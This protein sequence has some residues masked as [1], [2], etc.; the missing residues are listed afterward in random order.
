MRHWSFDKMTRSQYTLARSLKM[1]NRRKLSP[2]HPILVKPAKKCQ[3]L[4]SSSSLSLYTIM[5][6]TIPSSTLR[7]CPLSKWPPTDVVDSHFEATPSNLWL[8]IRKIRCKTIWI[9]KNLAP[10]IS[11]HHSC[12]F[13]I[14]MLPITCPGRANLFLVEFVK[15]A[16]VTSVNKWRI[17]I[18]AWEAKG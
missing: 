14:H 6:R 17:K 8:F 4:Y 18:R 2:Q 7:V 5:C 9:Y 16:K 10:Y 12:E 15:F 13:E 3:N 1:A 11:I